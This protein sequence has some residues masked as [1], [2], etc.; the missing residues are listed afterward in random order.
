VRKII[1]IFAWLLAAIVLLLAGLLLWLRNADLSAYQHHVESFVSSRIGH[2]L[3]IGGRFELRFG[4]STTLIAEDVELRNPNWPDNTDLVSVG[5]LTI[6]VDTWSA[7]GRPFII[8]ELYADNI[9]VH[10]AR[11]SEGRFNMAAEIPGQEDAEPAEFD[12]NR[13]AFRSVGLRSVEIAYIDPARPRPI[14]AKFD[15]LTISPDANDILDL[16]L[17]GTVNE[18]P[19]WADGKLGPWQN[20][21]DGRD[22]LADL[23]ISLG[24]IRLALEGT[25]ADLVALEG[26]EIDGSLSGPEISR[27]LERLALPPFAAGAFEVVANVQRLENGH[28]VRLEGNLGE[29]ELF[30]RGNFDN[31]MLPTRVRHDFRVSGPDV[32]PLAEL[33]GMEGAPALPFQLAGDYSR[34]D[35]RL[36]FK[37]AIARI[38]AN[39]IAFE[40]VVDLSGSMPDWDLHI[41]AGGPNLAVAGPFAGVE[42]LP[43]AAFTATGHVS[44][45]G[46]RWLSDELVIQV[47]ENRL[48]V[49]GQLE[50][51]SNG[52][53]EI[54]IDASGPDISFIQ[55]FTDLQGIPSRPYDISATIRPHR[56]GILVDDGVGVFG[57]NRLE[58][59]GVVA[60]KQGMQGTVLDFSASGPDL[61][62]IAVLT[63]VPYLPPGPFRAAGRIRLEK[64]GLLLEQTRASVRQLT[65]AAS[66]SIVISGSDAGDFDLDVSLSG[67]DLG[68]VP[69]IAAIEQLTGEPFSVA[70]K[71]GR[72]GERIVATGVDISLGSLKAR[73]NGYVAGLAEL[74]GLSVV[75]HSG[76]SVVLRKLTKLAYLPEGSVSLE[77]K[78]EKT[79]TEIKF[80][81]A[82]LGIG[83][84]KVAADGALNLSPRRNDSDLVFAVSGPDL[85]EIGKVFGFD[86][87]PNKDF[88]VN[89]GVRGTP[90]GFAL[91]DFLAQVGGNDIAGEFS[92][93]LS[94]KPRVV[95]NLESHYLDVTRPQQLPGPQEDATQSP[96]ESGGRLFSDKPLETGW[97]NKAD[98]DVDLSFDR[99]IANTI[100][101]TDVSVGIELRDG[102]LRIGPFELREGTGSIHGLLALTPRDDVYSL[103]SS[104]T[105][106][107]VHIGLL[108]AEDQ[109]KSS[110]PAL[111][112]SFELRGQGNSV[113]AIM[114]GA[115]G[116]MSIRQGSG[117]VKEVIGSFLFRDILV[118]V[119]RTLNPMR[120]SRDYQLLECGIY[121]VTV[122]DGLMTIDEFVIQTDIMTTVAQGELNLANERLEVG[123]RAKPREGIGISLGTV[124]N[125]LLEVRGT[126][127]EPRIRMDAGRTATTT[128]AAVATG[129]LSL[130]ARGLW[131][132]LSAESDVCKKK[133]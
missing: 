2:E 104:L 103:E 57:D 106:D 44:K 36:T 130:L 108:F 6:T 4:R 76:D 26:V 93:D 126:L 132:R 15:Q 94:G 58:V 22:I 25:I 13:I 20:L 86:A 47:G 113:R 38:G 120:K 91:R 19:L 72:D 80:S 59:D 8:E 21:V 67:P 51:G 55:D 122:E 42:G 60:M 128:G 11:D 63:D 65:A 37:D 125:Q 12:P 119:L 73:V 95:G 83:E 96:Q 27:V 85:A 56:Q 74:A 116:S 123:F 54:V 16:D 40:G 112:G 28:Q 31:L 88:S 77:G 89:G 9:R 33:F 32:S 17:N 78:F 82:A 131:D 79:A 62:N 5:N 68:V 64:D 81:D 50:T 10:L 7:L 98:I 105:I 71:L 99:L 102:A 18:L 43:Q 124:A 24:Q 34:D 35:R 133:D 107:Q 45:S 69:E 29:I 70:G 66:G 101:V 110:L 109:P 3:T 75:A 129:G 84:F 53:S 61:Q 48:A 90:S 52:A 39:S 97:L 115:N 1:R 100:D 49:N 111:T 30:V 121:R 14:D 41:D 23:D 114:A 117:K 118:E 92:V 127:K 87:L 46:S